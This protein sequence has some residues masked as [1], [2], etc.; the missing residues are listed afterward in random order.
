VGETSAVSSVA[1]FTLLATSLSSSGTRSTVGDLLRRNGTR[2]IGILAEQ[3][4]ETA[5]RARPAAT[6]AA[7]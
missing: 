7:N 3:M 1:G 4:S 5:N 2:V 6:S